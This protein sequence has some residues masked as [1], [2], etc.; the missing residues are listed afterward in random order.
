MRLRCTF[1]PQAWINDNAVRVDAED[2]EYTWEVDV[3]VRPEPHSHESDALRQAWSAPQWAKD[4]SGPFEVEFEVLKEDTTQYLF[5]AS[6]MSREGGHWISFFWAEDT[7]HAIEQAADDNDQDALIVVA[8][9]PYE[10]TVM[11]S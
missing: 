5:A 2:R 1:I 6:Y 9:V 7:Q 11:A 8:Q 4:W 10:S 3:E